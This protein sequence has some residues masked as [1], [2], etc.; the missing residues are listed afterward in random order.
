M[1][2][3]KMPWKLIWGARLAQWKIPPYANDS[4]APKTEV[5]NEVDTRAIRTEDLYRHWH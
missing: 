5:L 4:R 3:N 1:H 2:E